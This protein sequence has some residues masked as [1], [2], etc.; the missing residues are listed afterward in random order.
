MLSNFIK[1]VKDAPDDSIRKPLS[2]LCILFACSNIADDPQWNGLISSDA[3]AH[4][5]KMVVKVME[6]I[7]PNAVALVDAFD[8]PDNVLSSTI[9]R[10]DGNIYEALY[11]SAQKSVLN[12]RDPFD[13]YNEYLRP[14]L[15]LEFLSKKNTSLSKL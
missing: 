6:L 12:L 9:G 15:D 8:I 2:Q 14:H 13:G 7:R 1:A 11:E 10:Y 4:A 3:V 5:K